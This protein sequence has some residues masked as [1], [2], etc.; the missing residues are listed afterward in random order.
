MWR[1]GTYSSHPML[2]CF[3]L[4]PFIVKLLTRTWFFFI[5]TWR[6]CLRQFLKEM[7]PKSVKM[8]S[9]RWPSSDPFMIGCNV[10]FVLCLLLLEERQ[11]ELRMIEGFS[12]SC[13]PPFCVPSSWSSRA[14]KTPVA[15][16]ICPEQISMPMTIATTPYVPTNNNSATAPV[17]VAL[18]WPCPGDN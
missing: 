2:A 12:C 14:S 13:Q 17:M 1:M 16:W 10:S 7:S 3:Q 8:P 15:P 5:P 9:D 4:L 11:S 6:G 18:L